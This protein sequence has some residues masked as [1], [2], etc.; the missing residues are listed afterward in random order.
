[1]FLPDILKNLT[2]KWSISIQFLEFLVVANRHPY[3]LP[4]GL[5]RA[6]LMNPELGNE[7]GSLFPLQDPSKPSVR[8]PAATPPYQCYR[9]QC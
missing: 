4:L 5:P 7:K 9:T 3:H 1:M 8:Q 6:Q 2:K